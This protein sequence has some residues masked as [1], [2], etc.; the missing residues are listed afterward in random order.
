MLAYSIPLVLFSL[1]GSEGGAGEGDQGQG[2]RGQTAQEPD[3]RQCK[4]NGYFDHRVLA[5][6]KSFNEYEK[7]T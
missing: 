1:Q 7:L 2:G 3:H 4:G 5:G 6:A